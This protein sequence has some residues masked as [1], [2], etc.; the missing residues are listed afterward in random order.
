MPL[1]NKGARNSGLSDKVM[2]LPQSA[3]PQKTI[4]IELAKD[5]PFQAVN[6]AK[7]T[8]KNHHKDRRCE[9]SITIKA[10]RADMPVET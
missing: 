10:M 3:K 2:G 5:A 4:V 1:I 7:G 6:A 9:W 8:I